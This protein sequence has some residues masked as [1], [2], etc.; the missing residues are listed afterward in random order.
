MPRKQPG[1]KAKIIKKGRAGTGY[2]AVSRRI[3]DRL[4]EQKLA[5]TRLI[6][7]GVVS[8]LIVVGA[9][10]YFYYAETA[11]SIND[12]SMVAASGV[13]GFGIG[14]AASLLAVMSGTIA[15]SFSVLQLVWILFVLYMMYVVTLWI[16]RQQS[17]S[18]SLKVRDG[19][20]VAGTS[21]VPSVLVGAWGLL[22]LL[23]FV[24]LVTGVSYVSTAGGLANPLVR[25]AVIALVILAAVYTLYW[26]TST[27]I[28]SLI[29]TIPGTYPWA[30]IT[31][32]SKLIRG[33]RSYLLK[34]TVWL[35]FIVTIF[36]MV[37]ITPFLALDILTGN[38]LALIVIPVVTAVYLSAFVY[39]VAYIYELYRGVVDERAN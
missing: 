15:S 35:A 16:L 23:P 10:A 30:A 14:L 8:S 26:F 19:L 4:L 7:L 38:R 28:A 6:L 13:A 17:S 34:R 27:L 20:Y 39:A 12:L 29:A 33:Y 24:L 18:K 22:Q 36:T 37:V 11:L 2:V 31:T 1:T 3:L 25:V 21:I 32:A 5:Y 9:S